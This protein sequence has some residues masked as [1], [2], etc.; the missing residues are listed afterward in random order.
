MVYVNVKMVIFTKSAKENVYNVL[1]I[2]NLVFLKNYALFVKSNNSY[3]IFYW[4]SKDYYKTENK[5]NN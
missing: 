2:V 5:I 1:K 3:K 4:E